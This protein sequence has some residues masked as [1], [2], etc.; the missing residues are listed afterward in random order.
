METVVFLEELMLMTSVTGKKVRS[1]I[2]WHQSD[3][4]REVGVSQRTINECCHDFVIP[5]GTE[6]QVSSSR[7]PKQLR[8]NEN[9][10]NFIHVFWFLY[11]C[12]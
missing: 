5:V 12:V 3:S 2:G 11:I 4:F 9:A 7:D 10:L 8:T 1:Q 6:D